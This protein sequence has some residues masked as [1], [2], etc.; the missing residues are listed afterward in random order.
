[1]TEHVAEDLKSGNLTGQERR[2]FA[3]FLDNLKFNGLTNSQRQFFTTP[4]G[5]VWIADQMN[6][7]TGAQASVKS[8][9]INCDVDPF[10]SEGLKIVK[11][12]AGFHLLWNKEKFADPKYLYLSPMQNG[13]NV[14]GKNLRKELAGKQVMNACVLD[15]LLAN[16]E[17]IPESFKGKAIFFWGTI[18]SDSDGDLYVRYLYW[19]GDRW[20]SYYYWLDDSWYGSNPALL[21]S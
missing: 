13:G 9:M 21:V 20:I 3:N 7:Y 1:M 19:D 2:I 16:Q 4:N 11:H 17:Q 12:D 15:W 10:N 8:L 14:A 5:A 18:Y 6:L